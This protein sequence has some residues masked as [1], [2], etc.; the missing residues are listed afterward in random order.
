MEESGLKSKKYHIA[1]VNIGKMLGPMDSTIMHEFAVN[2]E[3]INQL[4]EQSEGFV[5][6]LKDDYDNATN[7]KAFEDDMII[8]NM[9]VWETIDDLFKFTYQTQH[10]DFL[11][12][13]REW[14]EK[15]KDM[16][17]VLWY[18]PAGTAPTPQDAIEKLKYVNAHGDTPHAFG[19]RKR[20]SVEDFEQA[21][22]VK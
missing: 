6:R 19:F 22:L 17:M 14:F 5:W 15:L 21:L 12:R 3:P 16:Y 7:I 11:K 2:L 13:R 9:S 18:I 8:I 10:T 4:A 20:F 1:Q